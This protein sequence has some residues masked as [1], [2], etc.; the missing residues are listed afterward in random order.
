MK[1]LSGK[2]NKSYRLLSEA[3]WEY[4]ARAGTTSEYSWGGEVGRNNA[5]CVGCGSRGDDDQTAPVDSFAPDGFGLHD[6]HGNVDEWVEDCWNGT[7]SG[8]PGDGNARTSGDCSRRLL[9]GGAWG[10][11]PWFVRAAS[12][13]WGVSGYRSSLNGFRVART[14]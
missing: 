7:C 13:S 3:E 11:H 8:A 9:R 12:R 10:V 6:M 5:N 14:F 1:W 4:A 2:T